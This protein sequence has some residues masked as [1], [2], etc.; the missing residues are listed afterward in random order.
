MDLIPLPTLIARHA[1]NT[2]DDLFFIDIEGPAKTF[3]QV[4]HD[5]L[6]WAR[7]LDD[8]GA[9][10]G[11]TVCSMLPPSAAAVES[12]LGIGW[13]GAW[14]VPVNTAYIGD[15]FRYIVNNCEAQIMIIHER[16]LAVLE[17]VADQLTHLKTVVVVGAGATEQLGFEVVRAD[18]VLPTLAP[19]ETDFEPSLSDVCSVMYTSGTTGPSKGVVVP[20]GQLATTTTALFPHGSISSDD[21][22]YWP[23]PMFHVSGKVG[24][25]IAAMY[26][27]RMYVR[28]QFKTDLFWEDIAEFECTATMLL[29]AMANFLVNQQPRPQDADSTLR[30][31][32]MIPLIDHLAEFRSRFDVQ[33]CTHYSMTET[34]IPLCSNGWVTGDSLSCGTPRP[35]YTVRLVD[36]NDQEVPDGVLGELVIRSDEPWTQMTE[37]YNM[38]EATLAAT[39]NQWLHTGDGFIRDSEG[40]YFF[41]DRQKDA[42]RRRGENISSF[43]VEACVN[44][45]PDV[46]ESAAVAVPSELSE[47]EILMVVVPRPGHE[48]D[49]ADL[50]G[51]CAERLPKFMVP[52]YIRVVTELPKTP[53][54][55]I[56]KARLRDQS[57]DASTWES[58]PT[59]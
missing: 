13:L 43:E 41:V 39:K 6:V 58:T 15:M 28:E 45:H 32:S 24:F 26:G 51:F 7:L 10:D 42:I 16:Y 56:Q 5:S 36:A 21:R 17:Q 33:V 52:R 34:S 50:H 27:A 1:Q 23:F 30:K 40:R 53:T 54:Q 59:R 14:E 46:L 9:G 38:P 25:G 3:A 19:L 20:W 47:D 48:L 18:D 55:K 2:G 22:L 29:G 12:W 11:T 35:G 37:Y 44:Q 49:P 57:I 4:H 31:V 8:L